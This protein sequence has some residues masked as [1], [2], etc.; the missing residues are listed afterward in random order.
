MEEIEAGKKFGNWTV[1]QFAGRRKIGNSRS[2]FSFWLCRCICGI[3]KELRR[4][5]IASKKSKSCGKCNGIKR[6]NSRH[7]R[8]RTIAQAWWRVRSRYKGEICPQWCPESNKDA[9]LDFKKCV[10]CRPTSKHRL[11]RIDNNLP[12]Q[13]GNVHWVPLTTYKINGEKC[14]IKRLCDLANLSNSTMRYRLK[15]MSPASAVKCA[16]MRKREHD[17]SN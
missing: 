10:K 4:D 13:P 12:W 17:P 7:G 6:V 3:E 8:D 5:Y 9:F 11:M 16:N 15:V 1:I 2:Q 14:T